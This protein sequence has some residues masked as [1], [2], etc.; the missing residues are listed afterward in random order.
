MHTLTATEIAARVRAGVLNPRDLH[1]ALLD[2]IRRRDADIGAFLQLPE[3]AQ[4]STGGVL[5]GVP[6]AV[7]D[8]ICWQD[9]PTTCA[10]KML[11]H[12]RPPYS[13]TVVELLQASGATLLGKT[14]M[15]E[16]AMGSSTETSA[17]RR[18]R[19]PW[20]L[21]RVPGGSS[22]GSAAAVAAG[23][24]PIALGSDTGGSIRQPAS[25][26]GVIGF[27]PTYGAVSRY[28]LIAF[29]SS[30]DQ[31]GVFA[32]SAD[33]ANL[34]FNVIAQP[35]PRDATCD[36]S[37][38]AKLDALPDNLAGARIGL[39]AE[40]FDTDGLNAEVKSVVMTAVEQLRARGATVK[41]I[42]LK[43]LKYA[44]PTYYIVA[45]AEAS[46][47]LARFD[48]AHFT[49]RTA[50]DDIAALMSRTRDQFFGEE[51]KRRIMLGTYVLSAGYY[52]AYYARALK[53]RTLIAREFADAFAEVDLIASPT[54]PTTAFAFGERA[55]DP[56]AMYL[57]DIYTISANLAGIPAISIPVGA[58]AGGLPVGLQLMAKRNA[59][60]SLLTAA[61]VC[62]E[63]S[64]WRNRVADG[65]GEQ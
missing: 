27:K 53:V 55:S 45:T 20:D 63:F 48:G 6:V 10:S 46:S 17:L 25:C 39:P 57:S 13:A 29:G 30:L 43:N 5:A 51:V 60:S 40:Y 62:E 47:N 7:K 16:F 1:A 28:G 64:G 26:C 38:I 31:I 32:R 24:C 18:T 11:E 41:N 23:F 56:L 4:F 35:D 65:A 36:P 19:N 42:R 58:D 12:F 22:G 33:D 44:V 50:A 2:R 52:D 61:K 59:D 37:A 21:T 9:Q 14:N 3:P 15:D 49:E 8:N 54:A 34:L